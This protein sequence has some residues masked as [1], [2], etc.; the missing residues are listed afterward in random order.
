MTK[1]VKY[2]MPLFAV[3]LL[4]AGCGGTK[5]DTV[6]STD[7]VSTESAST[8]TVTQKAAVAPACTNAAVLPAAQAW[9]KTQNQVASSVNTVECSGAWAAAVISAGS[10]TQKVDVNIVLK[11]NGSNWVVQNRQ[12]ACA[13]PS[14]VPAS[15]QQMACQSN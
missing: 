7:T 3:V 4:A 15:L 8:D 12:Q 6:T 10:A 1:T 2:L 5:T 14:P 11:A 9:A 13:K